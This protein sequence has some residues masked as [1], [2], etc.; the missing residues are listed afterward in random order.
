M[1]TANCHH[2]AVVSGGKHPNDL[3]LLRWINILLGNLKTSF[4]GII[5]A[6]NFDKYARP[7]WVVY[8]SDSTV[9]SRCLG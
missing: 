2:N 1:T 3:P 6:F 9:P 5:H 8:A 7:T 4:S